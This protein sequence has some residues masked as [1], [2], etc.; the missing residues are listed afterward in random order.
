[1][2]ARSTVPVPLG[3]TRDAATSGALKTAWEIIRAAARQWQEDRSLMLGAAL[4][5]YV[6]VSL[7]PLVTISLALASAAYGEE[8]L[9][10]HL[11][12]QVQRYV[13]PA[14]A[15][16][17]QEILA[18]TRE[19]RWGW[20]P[21]FSFLTLLLGASASFVQLQR[22]LNAVWNVEPSPGRPWRHTVRAR[23]MA[24]LLVAATGV[25]L[26]LFTLGGAVLS[27]VAGFVYGLSAPWVETF[28]QGLNFLL[29]VLVFTGIFGALFKVLPDAVIRWRDL[30]AGALFTSVLFNG[31]R[32]LVGLYLGKWAPGSAYGSAGSLVAV[33]LWLYFSAL[34]LLLGA[35]FTQVYARR[36]GARIRPVRH[37]RRVRLVPVEV[38]EEGRILPGGHDAGTPEAI[39]PPCKPPAGDGHG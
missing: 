29:G 4:A 8:A 19:R 5:F 9:Q 11:V 6:A 21:A 27:A 1:M 30:W 2:I 3:R 37:A 12:W 31:G 33:L 16:V 39:M 13:G 36:L 25:L 7:A 14:G 38:D 24:V 26:I 34:I 32:L 20:A 23:L 10:G 17:I 18:N 22:A 28:W 35:E 15:E